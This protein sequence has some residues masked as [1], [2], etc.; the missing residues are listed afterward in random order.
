MN[1]SATEG[2]EDGALKKKEKEVL[3]LSIRYRYTLINGCVVTLS[4][5]ALVIYAINNNLKVSTIAGIL[6]LAGGISLL[7]M[8]Y[9]SHKKA[10]IMKKEITVLK[11]H[12]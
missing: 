9:I 5:A 3:K 6:G 10:F 12:E 4:D 1:G 2:T 11:V 8:S 7:V